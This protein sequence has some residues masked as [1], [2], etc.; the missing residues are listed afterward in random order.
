MRGYFRCFRSY[1]YGWLAIL[2]LPVI[3]KGALFVYCLNGRI[4]TICV[5]S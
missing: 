1:L 3:H 2:L 5:A 4:I